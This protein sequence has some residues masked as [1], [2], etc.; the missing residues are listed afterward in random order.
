MRGRRLAT[1]GSRD[2]SSPE[3]KKSASARQ[4]AR[5]PLAE[6]GGAQE[7][8]LDCADLS[9]LCGGADLSAAAGAPRAGECPAASAGN[10]FP[11]PQSADESA[12]SKGPA[13]AR[14]SARS[15]WRGGEAKRA[16]RWMLNVES[17]TLNV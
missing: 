15:G 1:V 10:K 6:G 4:T 17:W 16:L 2:H 12:Q 5:T 9:A 3:G 11:P 14:S 13:T 8:A 7:G